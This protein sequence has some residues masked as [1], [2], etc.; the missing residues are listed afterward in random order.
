V[1]FGFWFLVF[2]FCQNPKPKTQNHILHFALFSS[3]LQAADRADSDIFLDQQSD[4][5]KREKGDQQDREN[6]PAGLRDLALEHREKLAAA[7][8]AAMVGQILGCWCTSACAC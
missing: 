6:D 2:G 5:E 3:H 1:V 4:P 8:R 7:T